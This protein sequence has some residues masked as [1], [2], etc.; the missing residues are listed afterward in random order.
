M[1]KKIASLQHPLVKHF[2]RLRQNRDYRYE[3]RGV[4]IDGIKPIT[5]LADKLQPR[6]VMACDESVIPKQV[7]YEDALI[8]TEAIMQKVS[9]MYSPEGLVAEFPMPSSSSLKNL[10]RVVALDGINDP[11]NLGTLLRSALA[12]GWE[13]VFILQES[14]DPYNEKALRAARGATFKLPIATGAWE[15]L[16]RLIK[17]NDWK[18]LAADL[19]G[20]AP[21]AISKN[22]G[23]LLI[24]GNEARGISDHA[25][26]IKKVSIRMSGPMESLNVAAAGAI[27]MYALGGEFS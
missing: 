1:I 2:V 11:G 15:D 26:T 6:T 19:E 13:G 27:L 16:Q 17:E 7:K 22:D 20:E 25:E 21:S 9:G 24:L 14:C 18:A 8:V 12:L 10:K 4:I 5:E 3:H 23:I